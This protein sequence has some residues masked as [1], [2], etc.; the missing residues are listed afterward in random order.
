[1]F[2]LGIIEHRRWKFL[3]SREALKI[4]KSEVKS[5]PCRG[6]FRGGWMMLF[7]IVVS[8]GI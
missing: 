3:T 5:L 2:D 1:M 6:R 4:G 7:R 8:I